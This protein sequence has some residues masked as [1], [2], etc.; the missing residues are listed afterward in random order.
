MRFDMTDEEW[1]APAPHRRAFLLPIEGYAK[2]GN[3][4]RKARPQ[5]PRNDLHLRNPML[6]QLSPHP[7]TL[8]QKAKLFSPRVFPD[9]LVQFL[10]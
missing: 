9:I 8:P 1:A 7:S 2:T 5:L 3:A 6:D 4:L 10:K